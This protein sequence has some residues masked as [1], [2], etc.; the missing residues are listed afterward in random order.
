[1]ANRVIFLNQGY[2][3]E[4]GPARQVL[5]TPRSDRLRSFLSRMNAI[6]V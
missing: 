3:E 2:V 5:T 1:V 6:N 4:E